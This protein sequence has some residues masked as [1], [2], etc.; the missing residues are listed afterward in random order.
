MIDL[1]CIYM[2][3]G[4]HKAQRENRRLKE[5]EVKRVNRGMCTNKN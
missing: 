2:D 3:Y 4:G 5:L 1:V